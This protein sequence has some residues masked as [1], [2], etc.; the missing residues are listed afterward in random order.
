MSNVNA[1]AEQFR[2]MHVRGQPIVLFNIWDA[3]SARAVDAAGAR[4]LATGSWAVA[5]AHGY[6]DG[7]GLP[8]D[9]AI[10]NL[11]RIVRVTQ[12]PVT[13]DLE[14]GYGDAPE[15][16]ARAIERS[17]E[18]GAVGCNLED[19]QPVGRAL[20]AIAE[21]TERF[22]QARKAADDARAPAYF[23]NGRCDVF[24]NAPAATHNEAMLAEVIERAKAYA[25]AGADGLFAPG[26]VDAP[27]IGRLA[28]R[29]PLPLNIM[30]AEATPSLPELASLGVARVSHGGRPYAFAMKA[31]QDAA[32]AAG[33][34][35]A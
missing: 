19:S 4:A 9:L 15:S 22:K 32:R 17:I 30:V 24:M 26:L 16:V 3:G 2:A 23:I 28:E 5:T 13:I 11:A 25:D 12:L 10:D 6:D 1:K 35:A 8:L 33:L 31:L 21:Q 18:A 7:E 27:L 29:S 34:Q 20:R 14:S